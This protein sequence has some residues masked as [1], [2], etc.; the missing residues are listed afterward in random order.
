MLD[1][2]RAKRTTPLR[3]YHHSCARFSYTRSTCPTGTTTLSYPGYSFGADSLWR[4]S[5]NAGQKTACRSDHLTACD[6]GSPGPQ[7]GP[8]LEHRQSVGASISLVVHVVTVISPPLNRVLG[9]RSSAARSEPD[10]L[11]L[12]LLPLVS[13]HRS[14]SSCLSRQENT[15][16]SLDKVPSDFFGERRAG[17]LENP[18]DAF[19]LGESVFCVLLGLVPK[20]A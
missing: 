5:W 2:R 1:P 7:Q 8:S 18:F 10:L 15:C 4:P 13:V 17:P 9:G 12:A 3:D 11:T 6:L 14:F 19:G 16:T 20:A